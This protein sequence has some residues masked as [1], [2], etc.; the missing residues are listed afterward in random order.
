MKMVL[1]DLAFDDAELSILITDDKHISQLNSQYLGRDGPT[2]VLA[3]P[4]TS[5]PPPDIESPMLG[6]VVVSADT[7]IRES[8]EMREPLAETICRLLIHGFLHLLHYDHEGSPEEAKRME[9]E[10]IRL[11][12]LIKK[13]L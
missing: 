10:E 3:F 2:N 9:K 6:D 1:E 7:A 8:D 13:D 12:A 5:G 11:L 4:M